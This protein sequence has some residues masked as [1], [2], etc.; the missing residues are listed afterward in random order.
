MNGDII[1]RFFLYDKEIFNWILVSFSVVVS[2]NC[3]SVKMDVFVL[4]VRFGL[5]IESFIVL[6]KFLLSV[7]SRIMF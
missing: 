3:L 1:G 5:I 6:V 2:D 4:E 7:G